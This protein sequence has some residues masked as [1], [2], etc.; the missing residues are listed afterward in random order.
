MSR[1]ADSC[2]VPSSPCGTRVTAFAA[3]AVVAMLAAPAWATD[4]CGEVGG[5]AWVLSG[6]PYVITCNVTVAAGTTLRVDAGVQ[7]A[8]Q[9]GTEGLQ[10]AASKDLLVR[11]PA[12]I[13]VAERSG[14][15]VEQEG[16]QRASAGALEA[17]MAPL[18]AL[19]QVR[20][21]E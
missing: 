3:L 10:Y 14:Q 9:A 8:F 5:E 7:V 13:G 1:A 11:L 20:L 4:K 12:E 16:V 15:T 6:S 17:R 21:S 2:S 19:E 18:P